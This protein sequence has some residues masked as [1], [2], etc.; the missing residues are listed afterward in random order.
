MNKRLTKG[1][2]IRVKAYP[3]KIIER[4]VLEEADTYVLCCRKEVFEEIADIERPY[5][6]CMGFPKEDVVEIIGV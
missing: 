1:Q 5:D 6:K 4:V 3:N 2:I